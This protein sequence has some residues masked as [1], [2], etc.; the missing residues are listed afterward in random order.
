MVSI[1]WDWTDHGRK[2]S[3]KK[4]RPEVGGS[5]VLPSNGPGESDSGMQVRNL[6]CQL[7][8][9]SC[10]DASHFG[11]EVLEEGGINHDRRPERRKPTKREAIDCTYRPLDATNGLSH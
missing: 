4:K 5:T 6:R 11:N 3:D 10:D 7:R 9:Q 2:I 8:L 1:A